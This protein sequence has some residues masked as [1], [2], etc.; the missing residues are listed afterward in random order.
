MIINCFPN[1]GCAI[2]YCISRK[3]IFTGYEIHLLLIKITIISGWVAFNDFWMGEGVGTYVL[4]CF[5]RQT[6]SSLDSAISL[7]KLFLLTVK[8][9]LAI[10]RA[11]SLNET[12]VLFC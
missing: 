11:I 6:N 12:F 10:R 3:S 2:V 8:E 5:C 4:L 7:G 9:F 1:D